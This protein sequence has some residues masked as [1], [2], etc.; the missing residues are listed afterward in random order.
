MAKRVW[1]SKTTI[2]DW[3]GDPI[4]IT[5]FED[6]FDDDSPSE[7]GDMRVL[8]AMLHIANSF[9][10]K[11]LD[12]STKKRSLKQALL[13]AVKTG[14]IEIE[15]EVFK[16]LKTASEA[17]CPASWQDNAN[18]VHDI[19]SEGF[20]YENEPSKRAKATKGKGSS[21]EAAAE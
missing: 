11:T 5:Q 12:D 19:I 10:C 2:K 6:P 16:W 20:T 7:V 1:K 14:K 18:E 13:K 15:P 17:V 8:D 3:R 4:R 9:P 21:D